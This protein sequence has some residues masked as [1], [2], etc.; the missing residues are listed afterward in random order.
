MGRLTRW[1]QQVRDQT[2]AT[3]A[4]LLEVPVESLDF[5]GGKVTRA[6]DPDKNTAI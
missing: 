3:A 6:D 1:A 5:Y 2:L 4:D